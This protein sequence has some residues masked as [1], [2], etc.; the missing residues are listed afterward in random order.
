MASVREIVDGLEILALTA[1]VPAGLAE[2]GETDKRTA[3]VSGAGHDIIYGPRSSPSI[4]NQHILTE[5]GWHF[6]TDQELWCRFV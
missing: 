4:E 2:K 6:D 3:S 1:K 5:L